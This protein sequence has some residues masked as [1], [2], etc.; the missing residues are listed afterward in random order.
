MTEKARRPKTRPTWSDVKV[1]LAE[2]DRAGLMQLVS[3]L[4][5]FDRDNQIFLHARFSLGNNP[6]DDYK[7]RIAVEGD[8]RHGVQ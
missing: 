4:Y 5:T 1:K 8:L 3:D 6:F 2:F 7:K